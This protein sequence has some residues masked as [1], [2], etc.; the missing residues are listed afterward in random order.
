MEARLG[1]DLPERHQQHCGNHYDLGRSERE[2]GNPPNS[3]MIVDRRRAVLLYA[4]KEL[5][6]PPLPH[7]RGSAKVLSR[8][9]EQ[10]AGLMRKDL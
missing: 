5:N 6:A 2:H 10:A 8:A 7:G 3:L 1:E 4:A 9:R